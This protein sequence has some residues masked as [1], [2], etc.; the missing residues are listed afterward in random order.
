MIKKVD[1]R[2]ATNL[3]H[4]FILKKL[5]LI[6]ED[7]RAYQSRRPDIKGWGQMWTWEP[8]GGV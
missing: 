4:L 3:N 8:L 1:I 2:T 5:A 6:C 7:K